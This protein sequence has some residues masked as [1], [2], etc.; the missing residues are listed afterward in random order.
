MFNA[1]LF[2]MAMPQKQP[3]CSLMDEWIKKM[4][5]T[6]IHARVRAHTHT[7]TD[8]YKMEHNSVIKEGKILPLVTT[9]DLEGIM[10]SE[11]IQ[12]E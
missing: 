4:W 7:H 8:T 12:M 11:V 1:A 3:M 5:Y 6:H 2:T 9:L 10:L